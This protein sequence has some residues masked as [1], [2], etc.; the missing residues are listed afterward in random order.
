MNAA[1][2]FIYYSTQTAFHIHTTNIPCKMYR[3]IFSSFAGLGSYRPFIRPNFRLISSTSVRYKKNTNQARQESPIEV[4][5]A[6]HPEFNHNING[7]VWDEF[8][9]LCVH[10][11][12]KDSDIKKDQAR[13]AFKKALVA[14]FQKLYGTNSKSIQAWKTLCKAIRISPIPDD[15]KECREVGRILKLVVVKMKRCTNNYTNNPSPFRKSSPCK[16]T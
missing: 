7:Q 5:F 14:E 2:S 1:L 15:I 11:K 13:H 12:W 6:K 3:R 9:A 8:N 4:F 10:Y 16:S